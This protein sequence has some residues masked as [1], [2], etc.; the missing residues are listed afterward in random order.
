MMKILLVIALMMIFAVSAHAQEVKYIDAPKFDGQ[1]FL[2]GTPAKEDVDFK[3]W[4]EI[5]GRGSSSA[6][7]K[8]RH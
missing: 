3:Q 8:L 5:Q 6:T 1:I 7:S 2:Y 4:Y